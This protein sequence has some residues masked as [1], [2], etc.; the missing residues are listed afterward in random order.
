[1]RVVYNIW[2]NNFGN[3]KAPPH[4][5]HH[6]IWLENLLVQIFKLIIILTL[7][8][9]EYPTKM[10]KLAFQWNRP[11]VVCSLQDIVWNYYEIAWQGMNIW[12][13]QCCN[14]KLMMS[15]LAFL[16]E[17]RTD[18]QGG[19]KYLKHMIWPGMWQGVVC[20]L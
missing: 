19:V 8:E 15:N 13:I 18:Y 7:F 10:V 11:L 5:I 12:K 2:H 1:M 20:R 6:F 4:W 16:R 14:Y 9:V 17:I 3:F